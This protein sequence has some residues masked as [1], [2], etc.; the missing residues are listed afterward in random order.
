MT[1]QFAVSAVAL[2]LVLVVMLF[3]ARLSR[4]NERRLLARGAVEPPGD[5]Y[6]AM[7][8]V[9]PGAFVAMAI[10]GA[11]IG[12]APGVTTAAGVLVLLA[13]KA[14][15]FWAI[16]SLGP[17]WT[18]RVLVPPGES[19]VTRGPYRRIR[20]PNYVGVI[21][22]LI[23]M[24]LLVGAPVSGPIGALLFGWLIWRRIA[25]ENRALTET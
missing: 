15:K 7:Q 5:V 19:L 21:G 8:V 6:R 22:E 16:A 25:V 3:E 23:G 4:A 24:A 9:Y 2:L 1:P 13:G 10:E 11:L 17:R 20:H 12:P 18:F 14:L